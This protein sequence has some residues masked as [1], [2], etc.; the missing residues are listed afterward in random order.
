MKGP[1]AGHFLIVC[2]STRPV[3]ADATS[4]AFKTNITLFTRILDSLLDGYDNRL[5]PGL[6]GKDMIYY[7]WMFRTLSF[8]ICAFECFVPPFIMV[9]GSFGMRTLPLTSAFVVR[10]TFG[11]SPL[12][13][14]LTDTLCAQNI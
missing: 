14:K 7:H 12:K 10:K 11:S 9:D 13:N 5:R 1:S 6:G 4:D 2:P 3:N 8:N